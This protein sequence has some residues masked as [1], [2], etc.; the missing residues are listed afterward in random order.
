M[1]TTEQGLYVIEL[2]SG[3]TLQFILNGKVLKTVVAN[4]PQVDVELP[5][6]A[7][8]QGKPKADTTATHSGDGKDDVILSTS[9]RGATS[10][11]GK[12]RPLWVLNGVVLGSDYGSLE[13]FAGAD[14]KQVAA[15]LVPGLSAENIASV[16]ILT[17]SSGDLKLR[18]TRY[19]WG[20]RDH[21]EVW[22]CWCLFP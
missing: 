5:V 19:R 3:Q 10:I 16:R 22:L 15:G 17:T 20:R 12:A 21:D 6:Q 2:E 13:S 4:Q 11:T 8:E 18:S 1:T 9:S 7:P 14:P